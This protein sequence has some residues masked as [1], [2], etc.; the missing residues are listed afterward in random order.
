VV[1]DKLPSPFHRRDGRMS[2]VDFACRI[3][4]HAKGPEFRRGEIS[5]RDFIGKF[6]KFNGDSP[7][8][9]KAP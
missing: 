6:T 3:G 8:R 1:Y 2:S 7:P 9:P 5:D 4:E